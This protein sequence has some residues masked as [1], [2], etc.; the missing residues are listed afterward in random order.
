MSALYVTVGSIEKSS[1][2]TYS[3]TFL[4]LQV[5]VHRAGVL[6]TREQYRASRSGDTW[7]TT[8][9]VLSTNAFNPE[10]LSATISVVSGVATVT[11]TWNVDGTQVASVLT[12]VANGVAGPQGAAGIT[13]NNT[14]PFMGWN[15][16]DNGASWS[17]AGTQ[18]STITFKQGVSTL[19]STIITGTINT[20]SGNITLSS[21]STTGSPT[22]TFTD[23]G[24]GFAKAFVSKEGSETGVSALAL[25]LGSLGGK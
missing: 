20:T 10:Q 7:S 11:A 1:T 16:G 18:S 6:L 23:N 13:S 25:N 22:I 12:I 2:G 19:A 5:S 24:T 15:S 3:A 21:S 4:D 17:P 8:L 9:T 14:Q